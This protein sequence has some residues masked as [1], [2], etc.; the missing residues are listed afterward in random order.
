MG[1]RG[2]REGGIRKWRKK[3]GER[4]SVD[5]YYTTPQNVRKYIKLTKIDRLNAQFPMIDVSNFFSY[6]YDF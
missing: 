1:R 5:R 4:G 2:G 3:E 6:L